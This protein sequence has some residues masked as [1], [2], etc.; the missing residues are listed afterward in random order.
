MTQ[1]YISQLSTFHEITTRKLTEEYFGKYWL[2]ENEYIEKW[3]TIHVGVF[4][5]NASTLPDKMFSENFEL[6][7]LIG[8]NIFTSQEDFNITKE[9]M[10]LAGDNY[11]VVIQNE[12]H[13]VQV[14]NGNEYVIH[15]FLRFRYPVEIS[16]DE[17]M[18]G[19]LVTDELFQSC[20]KEY[21]IFGDGG[22]W[23]RY[24]ANDYEDPSGETVFDPINL[25]GFR[26]NYCPDI[27]TNFEQKIPS[28]WILK[29]TID[30]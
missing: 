23:G 22:N 29:V 18:S 17:I 13:L 30:D 7:P 16:W 4:D 6:L 27:K 28:E 25:M 11:F 19:G 20:Y 12:K 9:L 1:E 3:H 26:K 5:P 24:A 21:F 10:R 14:Y 15:P 2:T 8:G